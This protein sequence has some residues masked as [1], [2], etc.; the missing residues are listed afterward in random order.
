MREMVIFLFSCVKKTLLI[1]PT[2]KKIIESSVG[3]MTFMVKIFEPCHCIQ[4]T[5]KPQY[6]HTQN[7]AQ[8]W[9]VVEVITDE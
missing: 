3:F 9:S 7:R 6:T 8:Q 5:I 1:P 2:K 4:K